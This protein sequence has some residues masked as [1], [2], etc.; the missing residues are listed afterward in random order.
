MYTQA[1]GEFL[2]RFNT[3]I[4]QPRDLSYKVM[5]P[6]PTGTNAVESALKLA[7]KVTGRPTVISFPMRFMA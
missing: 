3:T 7:R 4:L 1:K 2:Q 6:G 5:F